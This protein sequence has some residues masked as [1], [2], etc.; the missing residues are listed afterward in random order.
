MG[1]ISDAAQSTLTRRTSLALVFADL[2]PGKIRGRGRECCAPYPTSAERERI[3]S[4]P[5][6]DGAWCGSASAEEESAQSTLSRL[7]F[8]CGG[9]PRR[10]DGISKPPPS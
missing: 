8:G 2:P 6:R 1:N 5:P 9:L 4:A 3:R 7:A 10:G